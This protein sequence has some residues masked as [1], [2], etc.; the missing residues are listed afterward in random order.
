MAS[1]SDSPDASSEDHVKSSSDAGPADLREGLF[2]GP[3][4][5]SPS[6]SPLSSPEVGPSDPPLFDQPP[7]A[8]DDLPLDDLLAKLTDLS[9][10]FS[11]L[12]PPLARLAEPDSGP[13]DPPPTFSSPE[14]EL[15]HYISLH[16]AT[17]SAEPVPGFLRALAES[18]LV[19]CPPWT[20]GAREGWLL[21]SAFFRLGKGTMVAGE[22]AW[23][24]AGDYA[25]AGLERGAGEAQR[26]FVPGLAALLSVA[27]GNG[28]ADRHVEVLKKAEEELR[29]SEDYGTLLYAALFLRSRGFPPLPSA[30]RVEDVLDA[31]AKLP[32][33]QWTPLTLCGLLQCPPALLDPAGIAPELESAVEAALFSPPNGLP[34]HVR[35]ALLDLARRRLP[36]LATRCTEALDALADSLLSGH[37]LPSSEADRTPWQTPQGA[38]DPFHAIVFALAGREEAAARHVLAHAGGARGAEAVAA[39]I[40]AGTAKAGDGVPLVSDAVCS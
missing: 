19:A 14:E 18:A 28:G 5:V 37:P 12:D 7:F 17:P 29:T 26:Q 38:P 27:R 39:W 32:R 34:A 2:S 21:G 22:S 20:A 33:E 31:V 11:D 15:E 24:L 4:D 3:R 8:P 40:M 30:A 36:S 23:E 35:C 13:Q 10:P 16:G 9:V 25:E 6:P 1:D